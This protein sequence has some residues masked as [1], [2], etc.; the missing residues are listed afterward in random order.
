MVKDLHLQ[1]FTLTSKLLNLSA[2]LVAQIVKR[3]PTMQETQVQSLSREDPREEEMT[4]LSGILYGKFHG[5]RCL[6][7]Y[8][9]RSRKE[10]DITEN[11]IH[12]C[13]MQN[14]THR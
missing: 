10:L 7:G 9:P 5:R 3:L 2:C 11:L 13:L 8:S 12:T 6:M 4:A 1:P 14:L